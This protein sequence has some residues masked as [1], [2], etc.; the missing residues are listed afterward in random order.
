MPGDW[1]L[2]IVRITTTP[3]PPIEGMSGGPVDL[4]PAPMPSRW[5]RTW[6]SAL[7]W[8]HGCLGTRTGKAD[9]CQ[10]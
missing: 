7:Q 4:V 10:I 6:W 5:D 3:A 2:P 9:K 1:D 8:I